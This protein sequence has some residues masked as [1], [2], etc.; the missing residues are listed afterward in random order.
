[1]L[2]ISNADVQSLL[3]TKTCLDALRAGYRDLARG[4]AAYIPRID[5]HAPTGREDDYYRWGSMSGVCRS[6]GVVATRIK[7]DIVSWPG[8]ET[9][10]K[11]CIEP[12]TY[13][14][15]ILLYSIVNGEPLALIN[16]GVLQ[17]MR[18]GGSAGL[19]AEALAR[20]DASVLGMMGSGGMAE[21]Y[22]E[23]IA[24]V[25]PIQTVKVYSPNREHREAYARE[26]TRRLE[27][28]VIPVASPEEATRGSHIVSTA[29]DAM[30]PTF[31]AAW[32]EPGAHV[33]CVSRRELDKAILDRADVIVQL[34]VGTIPPEFKVPGLEWP[35]GG[36]ASYITGQPEERRRLPQGR[37][38]ELGGYAGLLE[39]E[40]GQASGRTSPDQVTLFINTGTQ[41]L[42]FAAVAGRTYQLAKERGLGQSMPLEWFLQDIRD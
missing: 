37:A 42:Q 34:G 41:G 26:M 6:M 7:S 3:D 28:E 30:S 16:D 1:M 21:T 13:S 35:Y 27:I 33:T 24:A 17:H 38:A 9:E 15:I 19:G 25:R 10:E 40:T 8:G 14:G 22:L 23:A 39:L 36:M 2:Y 31:E 32:V 11:W 18:V 12:G 29:T 5:I 4:D 20:E